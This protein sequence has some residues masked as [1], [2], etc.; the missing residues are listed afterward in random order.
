MR[1]AEDCANGAEERGSD[2]EDCANAKAAR[3]SVAGAAARW[4]LAPSGW[5][6]APGAIA[7]WRVELDPGALDDA[8]L[9]ADER[10]RA[11]RFHRE[12][13]RRRFVA[14]HA[15]F[16]RVLARVSGRAAGALCFELGPHGRPA[17][18]EHGL[19]A[20]FDANLAHAGALALVATSRAGR[21]G[22]DVEE[23][24]ALGDL[25]LLAESVL[26]PPE[27]AAFARL[28]ER[29]RADRKSVV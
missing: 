2:A 29:E 8:T 28:A 21:V 6:L 20:E 27:R 9:D 4:P 16:R 22:V 12:L 18:V 11:V 13:D 10:G 1:A 17:V 24:A 26:A 5:S 3:S 25:D 7:V 15:G 23:L 19:G 14:A